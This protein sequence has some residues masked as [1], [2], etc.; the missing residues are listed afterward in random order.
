MQSLCARG[1]RV[2]FAES[3]TG[4]LITYLLCM[5]PG[6]GT[7]VD[8]GL[9]TYAVESKEEILG[10][11]P[12]SIEE[13]GVYSTEVAAAMAEGML[14]I[15]KSIDI[16]VSVTGIAGNSKTVEENEKNVGYV[17]IAYAERNKVPTVKELHL[18]NLKRH[19]IQ[20]KAAEEVLEL[21]LNSLS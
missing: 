4:G 21:I 17:V 14:S 11:S 15:R 18:G 9:V 13:Y 16:A 10:L 20:C 8:C 5:H 6:A 12:S 19:E 2:A 1:K 7:V 3:C